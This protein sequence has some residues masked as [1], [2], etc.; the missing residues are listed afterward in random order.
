MAIEDELHI[1]ELDSI[2]YLM[3]IKYNICHAIL[4]DL[5]LNFDQFELLIKYFFR[6][7]D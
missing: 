6:T 1:T 7:T 3:L 5:C 4:D 2:L